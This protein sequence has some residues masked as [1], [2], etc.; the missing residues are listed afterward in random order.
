M[1]LTFLGTG[2]G[3]P[4]RFRNVA[5]IALTVNDNQKSSIWLFDCGEATQNQLLRSK[6]KISRINK[7]FITHLHGDHIY[8]L[9]GLL[10]GKSLQSTAEGVTLYGPKGITAYLDAV[11]SASETR[12]TYPLVINE[13]EPGTIYHSEQY[14]I[15]AGYLEHRIPCFGYR[16]IAANKSPTLNYLALAQYIIQPRSLYTNLKRAEVVT[17]TDGTVLNGRDYLIPAEKGKIITI[18]GD[19]KPAYC[20]LPLA[21]DADILVH[22]ATYDAFRE[23]KAVEYGHSTTQQAAEFALAANVKKLIITHISSRYGQKEQEQLLNQCR[24]IFPDT[25]LANDFSAYS[26]Y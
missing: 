9:P 15:V 12:I 20:A 1:I 14:S 13:I 10:G 18:F 2:A 7:I 4:T 19:T 5:S 26:I 16:I 8:G 3:T 22:E 23:Q 25:E 21:K 24:A 11:F 17:L 6:L